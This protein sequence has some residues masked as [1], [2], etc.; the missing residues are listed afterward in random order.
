M[1]KM[2]SSNISN[3]ENINKLINRLFVLDGGQLS[4]VKVYLG[5]HVFTVEIQ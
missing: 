5:N 1:S 4:Q 2:H 3:V